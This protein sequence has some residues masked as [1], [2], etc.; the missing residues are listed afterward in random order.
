MDL[1]PKPLKPPRSGCLARGH[2]MSKTKVSADEHLCW[3]NT[4][5]QKGQIYVWP[6]IS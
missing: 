3:G 5:L 4:T 1:T 2:D 6:V